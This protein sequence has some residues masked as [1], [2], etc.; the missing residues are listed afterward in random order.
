MPDPIKRSVYLKECAALLEVDENALIGE[1]NKLIAHA[2]QKKSDKERP[3]PDAF[4]PTKDAI[5][6]EAP[7]SNPE[8]VPQAVNRTTPRGDGYQELDVI[9]LLVQFGDK[10]LKKEQV[11]VADYV[12]SDIEESL[13]SFDNPLYGQIARLYNQMITE[14]QSVDQHFFIQ[15]PDPGIREIVIDILAERHGGMSHNWEAR[16]NYPL[17]NQPDPEHNF[18]E[19]TRQSVDRFKIRKLLK[20]SDMNMG[21]IK[22]AQES[23]DEDAFLRYTKVQMKIQEAR[24][25]IAQRRGTVFISK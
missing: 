5:A 6:A 14:G 3:E 17:Q 10:M 22:A 4:F 9:R 20:A 23:G 8:V 11:R 1:T 24:N 13:D 12:L 7:V 2:I 15:H 18:D 16:F 25:K 21:R 19:D